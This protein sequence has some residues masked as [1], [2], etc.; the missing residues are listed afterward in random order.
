V[1]ILGATNRPEVLDPA[2]L[3]PGRFDR[4]V[5]VDKPDIKGREE[6]LSI[7]TKGVKIAPNVDIKLIAARTAG[8]A[9]A[10]LANLVNE[11]AL[12]AARNDKSAVDMKDFESAI[13]R[14]IAGLE[15]KR[16]MSGKER[17]I[18]AYHESGHAIVATVLPNL[19]PVHKISI[20]QRGFGAL[21]YTMQL[22]LED[23]YLMQRR[24]LESQ[25]AVLL[26]G[27]TAEEIALGEISTGAQNDLQRATDI[28]RAMVTEFG[29][30]ETLG[31]VN[32]D[33]NKRARFLDIPLP[34][35]RGQY[36]EQTAEQ[37]D[38]EIKRI[39][40]DAHNKARQILSDNRDKLEKVTRR[41][42]EVEVM[43]G[44]ELRSMLGL[45]PASS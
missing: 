14:L 3:R 27:R 29:M 31:A 36:A 22:P 4:Q 30:S 23:R 42:L 9:G 5:L 35:E 44:D 32:Y 40:T 19:D 24:D 7:H 15:K 37:I 25:L 6:I 41:L 45:A 10:D 28:A 20:V 2:L 21:G 13:D 33:G 8:F 16:V 12:L 11:A 39:L 26:G 18:V 38:H 17:E 1:I 34:Q 43:E